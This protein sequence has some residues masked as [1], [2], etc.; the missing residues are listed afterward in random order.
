MNIVTIIFG[1]IML[2][3]GRKLFWLFI[4]C[5]GFFFGYALVAN[6]W[7]DSSPEMRLVAGAAIGLVCALLAVFLQKLAI[8]IGGFLGGSYLALAGVQAAGLELGLLTLVAVV[9][10]GLIGILLMSLAFELTLIALSSLAWAS[11]IMDGMSL[12]PNGIYAI[13]FVVMV[14]IGIVIQLRTSDG[15]SKREA[16]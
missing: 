8:G 10:A 15:R 9:V 7:A 13:A 12:A 11:L 3:A 1:L 2:F 14:L 4:A 6:G 16:H 5:L